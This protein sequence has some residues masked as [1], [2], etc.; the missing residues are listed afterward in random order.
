MPTRPDVP[1]PSGN[2]RAEERPAKRIAT[3]SAA[4]ADKLHAATRDRGA[5]T[6]AA[7]DLPA[8]AASASA[9]GGSRTAGADGSSSSSQAAASRSSTSAPLTG[10]S[11][12]TLASRITY[13]ESLDLF[14]F[15]AAMP[16]DVLH[17][18]Y[19]DAACNQAVF[20]SCS[21][22]EQLL[23]LRL[24]F[25]GD[26]HV[27][28]RALLLWAN[29]DSTSDLRSALST[30]FTRRLLLHELPAAPAEAS[31]GVPSRPAAKAAQYRVVPEFGK[32]LL[33]HILEG[34]RKKDVVILAESPAPLHSTQTSGNSRNKRERFCSCNP[35]VSK[36]TSGNTPAFSATYLHAAGA[37]TKE[38]LIAHSRQQW[39]RLLRF[40]VA[41]G[42]NS[43]PP[44]SSSEAI[45]DAGKPDSA[46]PMGGDAASSSAA[47]SA[48]GLSEGQ[49]VMNSTSF[50]QPENEP[51]EADEEHEP[52]LEPPCE[53][54]IQ[55]LKRR[56]LIYGSEARTGG[57]SSPLPSSS[58][59]AKA[60]HMP[61]PTSVT[62]QSVG[63]SHE[64]FS[65]LLKDLRSQ[66]TSL[67]VEYMLG[68]DDGLLLPTPTDKTGKSAPPAGDVDGAV[69]S[70]TK[71]Q[72]AANRVSQL[73]NSLLLIHSS[74]PLFAL[75]TAIAEEVGR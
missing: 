15:I 53:A 59:S 20:R 61:A 68:Q 22:L 32:T 63:I 14:Q 11:S 69:S 75:C 50:L 52:P 66:M 64:A 10:P 13:V 60:S 6:N 74:T 62:G 34:P 56:R 23:L 2:A 7:A 3:A 38:S 26:I 37:P 5:A 16:A 9:A 70:K 18:L 47:S 24:I 4:D 33:K 19:V 31:G 12:S 73:R 36:S 49:H 17:A 54:V 65:W 29:A 57:D 48:V 30:L 25:L 43:N 51:L 21:E 27:S 41:G 1:Q 28:E 71:R 35:D 58:S 8:T 55:I 72:I 67:V 40:I 45:G 39:D 42:V 44:T 46:F